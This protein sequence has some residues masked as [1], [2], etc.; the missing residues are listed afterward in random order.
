MVKR[1]DVTKSGS[2]PDLLKTKSR[3]R[4]LAIERSADVR[5]PSARNDLLPKIELVHRDPRELIFPARNVRARDKA[6]VREVSNSIAAYGFIDPPFIDES[7]NVLDGV[8][9]VLAAIESGLPNIPCIIANHLSLQQRRLVRLAVNRLQEKGTWD[10]TELSIELDELILENAPIELTGFTIPE[11]DQVTLDSDPSLIEQ[12]PLEPD[13]K[14]SAEAKPGDI[15]I[16][17]SHRLICGS[18][19]DAAVMA[20]LMGSELTRLVLTDEP[21]NV[22]IKNNVTRGSHREFAMA[23]G[24]M[25]DTEFAVFNTAWMTSALKFLVD[26]G[27]CGTFIDWRGLPTVHLAATGLDLVPINLIVW[28]KTNAGMGSLYRSQHELLPLFKKGTATHLNNVNL[29][30]SGG[31]WRSNVWR[32]PG[33]SSIS[34]DARRGLRDHPTVKPTA[35]IEDALLDLTNRGE[36]VLDPFLGSGSTLIA[37]EKTGRRCFGVEIDPHYVDLI[38]RRYEQVTGK[39]AVLESKC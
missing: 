23:S 37:A 16:L 6:H 22:K 38:V 21:Y 4:R 2:L 7:N 25:S 8:V 39:P 5:V 28:A 11:I 19:T 9:R 29:G 15:Y 18:A 35:M 14:A 30:K 32:Y 17:G 24:E 1:L 34:S 10:L 20:A 33:A 13:F 12:G 36:I 26:G 27:L 3:G 31:R